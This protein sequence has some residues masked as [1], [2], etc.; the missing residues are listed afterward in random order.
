MKQIF[1]KKFVIKCIIYV[2]PHRS[3]VRERCGQYWLQ[4]PGQKELCIFHGGVE[5]S[6]EGRQPYQVLAG[7][8]IQIRFEPDPEFFREQIRILDYKTHI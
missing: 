2:N 8:Q 7:L 1:F 6:R 5:K 4:Q 3:G